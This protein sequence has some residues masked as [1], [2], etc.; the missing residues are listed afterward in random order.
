M[1]SADVIY[2]PST[3]D[4]KASIPVAIGLSRSL[5]GKEQR[6]IV[7]GDADFLSNMELSRGNIETANFHFNTALFGWFAYGQFPVD[8]SHPKPKDNQLIITSNGLLRLQVLLLGVLPGILLI[9]GSLLLIR[10]KRK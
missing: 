8:T 3:G 6:I 4:R 5:K 7:T 1:D 10:R 9:L 2:S